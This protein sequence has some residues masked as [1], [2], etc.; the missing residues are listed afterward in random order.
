MADC[1]RVASTLRLSGAS[2]VALA[3]SPAYM[4]ALRGVVSRL[5][6]SRRAERRRLRA[7]RTPAR[8]AASADR[9]SRAYRSAQRSV[10]GLVLPGAPELHT[11]IVGALGSAGESYARMATAARDGGRAAWT[12]ARARA[13]SSERELQRRLRELRTLG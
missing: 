6:T 13:R 9:L 5:E 10:E 8:Q 7:A 4:R 12:S 3:T 1:E 2:P 11:A